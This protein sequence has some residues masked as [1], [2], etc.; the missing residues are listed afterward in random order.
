MDSVKLGKIT[1]P[2]GIKGEVRVYPYTDEPT[3]F[4]SIEKLDAD[5]VS[6]DVEKVRYLKNMVILKLSGID[7]RNDAEQMRGKELSMEKEMLWDIPEDT[8]FVKDLLGC[9]ATSED[10]TFIGTLSDVI[11]NNAQDL[12]EITKEDGNTFLLPAVKEFVLCVDT[13]S[14]KITVR[15]VEGLTDL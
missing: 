6:F 15:L 1:A 9:I 13:Q 11:K 3:R 4:S 8:Y 2:V 12:Y 10:G 7:S 14:K 5:G